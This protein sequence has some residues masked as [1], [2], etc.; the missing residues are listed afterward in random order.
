MAKKKEPEMQ[1]RILTK[2]IP[3]L[4]LDTDESGITI[5]DP[6]EN[7]GSGWELVPGAGGTFAVWTGYIDLT[8]MTV[9]QDLSLSIQTVDVQEC[10]SF[11]VFSSSMFVW[12]LVTDVPVDWSEA[13]NN[14]DGSSSLIP[15]PGFI[16][17]NQNIENVVE[18]KFR[19]FSPGQITNPADPTA[20]SEGT[21][22]IQSSRWG[23]NAATASDRLYISRIIGV[24]PDASLDPAA[25]IPS[26]LFAMPV[27][28][29]EEA[30][31][32]HMERLR[33]S[34]ILQGPFS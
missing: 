17:S 1:S 11:H 14:T 2:A 7:V 9:T 22:A 27:I 23:T 15:M 5:F 30:S 24:A 19:M 13:L 32:S 25:I 6:N 16:G 20:V 21:M 3:S 10:F 12:D 8:G 26:T 31:L 34:Y 33:R 4:V 29:F 28:F 18:G